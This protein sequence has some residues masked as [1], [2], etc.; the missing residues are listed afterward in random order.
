MSLFINFSSKI[1]EKYALKLMDL[2]QEKRLLKPILIK[3]K[4][5]VMFYLCCPLNYTDFII[6]FFPWEI[7]TSRDYKHMI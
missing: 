3:V 1:S 7:H 2:V 4:N 5:K 6:S